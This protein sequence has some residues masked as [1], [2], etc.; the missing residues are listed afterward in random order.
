MNTVVERVKEVLRH[1]QFLGVALVIALCM[2]VWLIGCQSTTQSILHPE[3]KITRAELNMEIKEFK[4]KK[5]EAVK[6]LDRQDLFK[7]ELFNIGLALAEGGTI[8]PVGAGVTL[9]SILGIGAVA[10]NRRKDAVIKSKSNALAALEAKVN[11][12]ADTKVES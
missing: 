10:D 6:D 12:T 7:Q 1:N 8:N 5:E 4:A 2:A 9:L 11:I 3:T